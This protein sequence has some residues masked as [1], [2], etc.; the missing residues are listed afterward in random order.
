MESVISGAI[1]L[2]LILFA[3]LTFAEDSVAAQTSVQVAWQEMQSRVE[4]RS[5]VRLRA[6]NARIVDRGAV[7]E[8]TLVNDGNTKLADFEAWDTIVQYSDDN[9]PSQY[10]IGHFS[11]ADVF[12]PNHW[13]TAGIFLA[14][15][16]L[17]T[18]SFE[19]GILNPSEALV[20]R[21]HL[22]PPVGFGTTL[23]ATLS[24][25]DGVTVST[26]ARR[27]MPP[28]LVNNE[29]LVV[30]AHATENISNQRL[31]V[32]DA[33]DMPGEL[34]Y[35]VVSGPNAGT[36]TTGS[37][38]TQADIDANSVGYAH[39]LGEPDSFDFTVSDGIDTIGPYTFQIE[40]NDPPQ[41]VTN[42]RLILSSPLQAVTV[43]ADLLA[44][45]DPDTTADKL[46][47]TVLT[48]PTQGWL[49]SGSAFT[50]A[51]IDAGRLVYTHTGSESDRFEF[52]VSDGE[53]D[54]GTYTFWIDVVL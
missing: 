2:F 25:P 34:V 6:S 1:I 20:V 23:L 51:D 4:T 35:T 43:G 10:H 33:D 26:Q 36:L 21:I 18:E 50:Q 27:N 9:E 15:Q 16:G 53:S 19:P 32:S 47:Y 13:Q 3:V 22:A 31:L 24:T 8:I 38:F 29:T 17:V 45:V 40:I 46:R 42:N 5:R 39:L 14:E 54:I 37:T 12:E 41:L 7:M 44:V 30:G 49:S 52:S 11:Y 28:V 48:G